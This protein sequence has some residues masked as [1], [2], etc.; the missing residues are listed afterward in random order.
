MLKQHCE[1]D[2]Q[3]FT[4]NKNKYWSSLIWNLPLT[5]KA[6]SNSIQVVL[7]VWVTHKPIAYYVTWMYFEWSQKEMFDVY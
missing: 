7:M 4:G 6:E 2:L 1:G 5:G 3:H